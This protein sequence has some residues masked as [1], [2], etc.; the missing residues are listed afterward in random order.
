[1]TPPAGSSATGLTAALTQFERSRV[2]RWGAVT[3]TLF[4]LLAVFADL[5]AAD[6]PVACRVDGHLYLFPNLTR[7]QPL[8]ERARDGVARGR[9]AGDWAITPVVRFG[10]YQRTADVLKPPSRTHPLGTDSQGRDVFARVVHGT[11]MSLIFG[12][13]TVGATAL[14]GLALG[15]LAGFYGRAFDSAVA[16]A[17]ETISS[18]P[19]LLL[20][21]V[22]QAI[23][24]N[25]SALT[26]MITIVLTRWTE[27]ARLVRAEVLFASCQDYVLA[28]RALG[29]SPLRTLGRHILPNV[30]A[31]AVVTATF[32]VASVILIEAQL[33][34]LRIGAPPSSAS[35]GQI[36]SEAR[37]E[38][39]AWWLLAFPGAI[40]FLTIVAFNLVGDALRDALDPR[41]RASSPLR[42]RDVT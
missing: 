10:P 2:A 34:F 28:A 40:L 7:P 17:I 1:M 20:V 3:L 27:M 39:S 32:G 35:W 25:P 21:L 24:A 19:T 36:L 22:V 31:P 13:M 12:C 14:I 11:R 37:D 29:A 33:D 38:P 5:L 15:A 9:S 23:A 26:M 8:A 30:A 4:A 41:L 6:L 18:F 16:R 42:G